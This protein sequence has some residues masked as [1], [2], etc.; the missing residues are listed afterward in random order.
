MSNVK[1]TRHIT[2]PDRMDEENWYV[3]VVTALIRQFNLGTANDD[4]GESV[5]ASPGRDAYQNSCMAAVFWG[6]QEGPSA[7]KT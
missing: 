2:P 7:I 4:L 5:T 1:L 3:L 6:Q